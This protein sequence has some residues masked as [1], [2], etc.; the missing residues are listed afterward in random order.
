MQNIKFNLITTRAY[1]EHLCWQIGVF[2]SGW[3]IAVNQVSS[4]FIE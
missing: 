1:I 2:D 4:L 3:L